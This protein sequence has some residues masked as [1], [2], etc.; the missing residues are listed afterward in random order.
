[1][2]EFKTN[3]GNYPTRAHNFTLADD[4]YLFFKFESP[5]SDCEIG[6]AFDQYEDAGDWY[7]SDG[8]LGGSDYKFINKIV[9]TELCKS[10]EWRR[11]RAAVDAAV[12][13]FNG[14]DE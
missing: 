8:H 7:V 1:M 9:W 5:E 4:L 2:I 3:E 12:R 11:F 14:E 6:I 10:E 13:Q